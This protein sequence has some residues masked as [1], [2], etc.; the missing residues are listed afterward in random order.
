VTQVTAAF[1][2]MSAQPSG[3]FT[4]DLPALAQLLKVTEADVREYFTDGRRI[5]FLI[6]R[7][8][9]RE[10]LGGKLAAS[11][12]AAFDLQDADGRKWEVRSISA[13]GIYFS[14]SFMVGSGRS[15][16]EAGFLAKV[17]AISGYIVSDIE[18]FP[19][20]PFWI[21]PSSVVEQWWRD[22]EL[23]PKTKISRAKALVLLDEWKP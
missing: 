19:D 23:G 3:R 21:I 12:G 17:A 6:E 4:W 13:A 1:F 11:E 16:V 14:P 15:F 5:S 18:S 22:G 20:V 9:A 7:R 10:V 2:L 8:L